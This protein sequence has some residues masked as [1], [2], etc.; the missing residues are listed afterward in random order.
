MLLLLHV[1]LKS[2][3]PLDLK[4][5]LKQNQKCSL[6]GGGEKELLERLWG[7]PLHMLCLPRLT[8]LEHPLN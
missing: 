5:P 7:V 1:A 4:V 2:I 3:L 6:L 8:F